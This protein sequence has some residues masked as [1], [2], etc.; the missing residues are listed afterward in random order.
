MQL[1]TDI[2]NLH[3]QQAI[4]KLGAKFEGRLRNHRFRRDGSI[5]DT[6]M[7]SIT[8]DEWPGVREALLV[9]IS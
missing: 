2:N 6:M 3:S 8:S 4:L 1:K 7:F 5:R 9:R